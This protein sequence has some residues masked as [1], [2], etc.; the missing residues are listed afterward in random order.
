MPRRPFGTALVIV[1]AIASAAFTQIGSSKHDSG[2]QDTRAATLREYLAAAAVPCA[3]KESAHWFE[4]QKQRLLANQVEEVLREL[5]THFEAGPKDG[6]GKTPPVRQAHQYIKER[7][8]WMDYAGALKAKLPIG[9][10]PVESAHRHIVQARVKKAGAWW[11]EQN[12]EDV[13]QMRVVR[14]NG[15]WNTYWMSKASLN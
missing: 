11:R 8:D 4:K 15:A 7:K 2:A 1:F 6:E 13:V 10:G 3:G 9:S 14:A 5:Q 12:V